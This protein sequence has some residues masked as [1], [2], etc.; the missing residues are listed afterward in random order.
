[1]CGVKFYTPEDIFVK[2]IIEKNALL[3]QSV[4]AKD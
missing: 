1:M 3:K 4:E 2:A